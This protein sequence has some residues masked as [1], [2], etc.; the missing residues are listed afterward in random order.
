MKK[1]YEKSKLWN[2]RQKLI[3]LKV[4]WIFNFFGKNELILNKLV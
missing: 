3:I 4:I 2:I 1:I